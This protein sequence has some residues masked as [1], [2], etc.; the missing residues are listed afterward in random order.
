MWWGL[1][2][3]IP[4]S[5]GAAASQPDIHGFIMRSRRVAVV[6]HDGVIAAILASR[7]DHVRSP[8]GG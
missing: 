7:A 3:G 1:Q 4:R 8:C 5:G 6:T 2:A